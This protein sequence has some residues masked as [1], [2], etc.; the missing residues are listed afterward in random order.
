MLRFFLATALAVS[1]AGCRGTPPTLEQAVAQYAGSPTPNRA[2]EAV[3]ASGTARVF[4]LELSLPTGVTLVDATEADDRAEK[5]S[6]AALDLE[7]TETKIALGLVEAPAWSRSTETFTEEG[8]QNLLKQGGRVAPGSKLKREVSLGNEGG[9]TVE[10]V[11]YTGTFE[12]PSDARFEKVGRPRAEAAAYWKPMLDEQRAT[13]AALAPAPAKSRSAP[14]EMRARWRYVTFDSPPASMEDAA[15]YT[16]TAAG[17]CVACMNAATKHDA[18]FLYGFGAAG[19]DPG[20]FTPAQLAAGVALTDAKISIGSIVERDRL[21]VARPSAARLTLRLE[22]SC[23]ARVV[24]IDDTLV[25]DN[26]SGVIAV[27]RTDAVF[28]HELRDATCAK[29]PTT[30]RDVV[31]P[32][33]PPIPAGVTRN[34]PAEFWISQHKAELA[35]LERHE[36]KLAPP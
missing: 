7:V 12:S 24:R 33:P 23:P 34:N 22:K 35:R 15:L 9:R 17:P 11:S 16:A 13:L 31:G 29:N 19:V 26:G 27:P 10:H 18:V 36:F 25:V 30:V 21:T 1:L 32:A 8:Y 28:W 14:Y 6:A 20:K 4:V 5:R 3:V 2:T